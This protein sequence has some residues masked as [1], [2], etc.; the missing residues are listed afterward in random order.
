MKKD[1]ILSVFNDAWK[2]LEEKYDN[3]DYPFGI[4]N[5]AKFFNHITIQPRIY[6]QL[7]KVEV[8]ND[9]NV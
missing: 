6:F 2:M 8:E 9:L 3:E 5:T 4:L 1:Q 7:I